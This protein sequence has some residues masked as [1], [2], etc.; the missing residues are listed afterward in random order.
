MRPRRLLLA[1]AFIPFV[2]AACGGGKT[3]ATTT[4]ATTTTAEPSTVT[5]VVDSIAVTSVSHDQ[6][7]KGASKGDRIVFTD[8]LRNNAPQFGEAA[9]ATVGKDSG[10]MSFTSNTAARLKGTATLPN[11]TITFDGAV[12]GNPDGTISVA[13]VGGTGK[14]AHV[15]G[16]LKVGKG[17]KKALNTYTLTFAGAPATGPVA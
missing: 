11:G 2:L 17:V 1:L 3:A 5:I 7:P 9:A 16:S 10:T 4:Q 13:V 12:V 15:T 8:T 14:Y 6:L